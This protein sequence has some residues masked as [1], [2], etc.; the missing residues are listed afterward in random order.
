VDKSR[1]KNC[2]TKHECK[3]RREF[4]GKLLCLH[5]SGQIRHFLKNYF[6]KHLTSF[7][8]HCIF[9]SVAGKLGMPLSLQQ[10]ENTYATGFTFVISSRVTEEM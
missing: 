9:L 3:T 1:G 7:S 10:K 4:S 8:L 6:I 2:K 5:L